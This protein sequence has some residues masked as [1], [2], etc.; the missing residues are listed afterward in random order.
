MNLELER[1]LRDEKRPWMGSKQCQFTK[2]PIC[3]IFYKSLFFMLF[4]KILKI[5]FV[6]LVFKSNCFQMNENQVP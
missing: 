1:G 4:V 2:T 6:K 5:E 3:R